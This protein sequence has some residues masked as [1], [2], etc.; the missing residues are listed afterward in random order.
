[1][2]RGSHKANLGVPAGVRDGFDHTEHLYQPA[3]KAGDVI[4]FAEATTHGAMPWRGTK[5]RRVALYRF[6]PANM[7]Y[8]RGYL[9]PRC[10]ESSTTSAQWPAE[11]L[12]G[13]TD[14]QLAILQPPFN[15][16]LDRGVVSVD[17]ADGV[18][19]TTQSREAQKRDFDK[20]LFGG[21][22]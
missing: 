13:A 4:L 10:Q 18:Q 2:L 21:Y 7:A 19:V 17:A 16:R 11:M 14:A 9:G 1:M 5:P 20:V 15:A 8:G 12:E 6:A 22:F 3:L